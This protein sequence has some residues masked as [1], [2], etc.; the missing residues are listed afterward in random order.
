MRQDSAKFCKLDL[1]QLQTAQLPRASKPVW[2]R[3]PSEEPRWAQ[4]NK[5]CLTTCATEQ[6]LPHHLS[7]LD[8]VH[9]EP[10]KG[11]AGHSHKSP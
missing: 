7:G 5:A 6:G 1:L 10:G 2:C 9:R 8:A 4:Q 3:T 11:M